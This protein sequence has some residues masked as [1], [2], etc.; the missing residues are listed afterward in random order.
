MPHSDISHDADM[1]DYAEALPTVDGL[2]W[3]HCVDITH[4]LS[5]TMQ[6]PPQKS[7]KN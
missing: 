5:N 1:T 4:E 7:M 2:L 6:W 3:E